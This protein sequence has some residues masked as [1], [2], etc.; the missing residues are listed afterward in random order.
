[1]TDSDR[2]QTKDFMIRDDVRALWDELGQPLTYFRFGYK[3][4]DFIEALRAEEKL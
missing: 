3:L 2:N 4:Q 1:M